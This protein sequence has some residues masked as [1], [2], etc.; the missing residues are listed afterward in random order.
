MSIDRGRG[1]KRQVELSGKRQCQK[2]TGRTGALRAPGRW[3]HF[4]IIEKNDD[5]ADNIAMTEQK[6]TAIK[7]LLLSLDKKRAAEFLNRF[8]KLETAVL[9][10]RAHGKT[11][12]RITI[13]IP[14]NPRTG[15]PYSE[16]WVRKV[17]GKVRDDL[18]LDDADDVTIAFMVART[19]LEIPLYTDEHLEDADKLIA[20]TVSDQP[21]DDVIKLLGSPE[22]RQL[23]ADTQSTGPKARRA[24]FGRHAVTIEI[25]YATLWAALIL[26]LSLLIGIGFKV[27]Y[28]S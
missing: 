22:A 10:A 2:D 16:I 7:E 14:N 23:I 11:Y 1:A 5:L 28:S 27:L 15:K 25:G 17:M 9:Q 8:N 4:S 21:I 18:G 19:Q 3:H 12:K 26:L 20:K 6:P 24:K 13:A